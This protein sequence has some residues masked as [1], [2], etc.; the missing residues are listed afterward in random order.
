M[1]SV[2]VLLCVGDGRRA[3]VSCMLSGLIHLYAL[4][5]ERRGEL[6]LKITAE[7]QEKLDYIGGL[8]RKYMHTHK[9]AAHYTQK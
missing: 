8:Q 6:T 1:I 3:E 4:L 2:H 9:N 5:E 7:Q